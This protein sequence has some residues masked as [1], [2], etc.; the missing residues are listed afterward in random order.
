MSQKD[1]A[2]GLR[3]RIKAHGVARVARE[4]G[5]PA[6]TLYSFC[7]IETREL[8]LKTAL[9]VRVALEWLEGGR[10]PNRALDDR[11]VSVS[12]G[13]ESVKLVYQEQRY[14]D[15]FDRSG[16]L[17]V[18]SQ[19]EDM[20]FDEDWLSTVGN[21]G[22]VF[23]VM[24]S[25]SELSEEV[26]PGDCALVDGSVSGIWPGDT[27]VFLLRFG[28]AMIFAR[29][30]WKEGIAG[31]QTL[32]YTTEKPFMKRARKGQVSSSSVLGRV[33]WVGR[34]LEPRRSLW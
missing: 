6:T 2:A 8:G 20:R 29:C 16:R 12:I 7:K 15:Q 14:S 22:A 9:R 4:A 24:V 21:P 26:R 17:S 28:E 3:A 10:P 25:G 33:V 5:V 23:A 31:S 18:T 30:H 27:G 13:Y 11:D 32:G 19:F 34:A 1:L